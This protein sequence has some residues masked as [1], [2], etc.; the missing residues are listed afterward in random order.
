MP[1]LDGGLAHRGLASITGHQRLDVQFLQAEVEFI[2]AIGRVERGAG[3][4]RRNR[5]E[6][7]RHFRAVWQDHRQAVAR[8]D[9]QA[10]QLKRRGFYEAGKLP[11]R[12]GG[13]PRRKDCRGGWIVFLFKADHFMEQTRRYHRTSL[14]INSNYIQQLPDWQEVFYQIFRLPLYFEILG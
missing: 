13:L 6:G 5:Q 9:P 10:G 7:R 2:L 1:R 4:D 8:P 3:A 14:L 12:Q 11:V